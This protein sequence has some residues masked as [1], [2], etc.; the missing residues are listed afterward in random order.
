VLG[1]CGRAPRLRRTISRIALFVEVGWRTSNS[2][3]RSLQPTN[4]VH[5]C[6]ADQPDLPG[7]LHITINTDVPPGV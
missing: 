4:G 5:A 1:R 3:S 7:Q 6:T 2:A